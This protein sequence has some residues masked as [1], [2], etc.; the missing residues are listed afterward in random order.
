[1]K[2]SLY[3]SKECRAK[4]ERG[5][6]SVNR[7]GQLV[8]GSLGRATLFQALTGNAAYE[9]DTRG[10]G[11]DPLHYINILGSLVHRDID[12]IGRTLNI[13]DWHAAYPHSIDEEW[14]RH[15]YCTIDNTGSGWQVSYRLHE[16]DD[17]ITAPLDPQIFSPFVGQTVLGIPCV[18][19]RP[20]THYALLNSDNLRE[21]DIQAKRLLL[22]VMADEER[23]LLETPSFQELAYICS[24]V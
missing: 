11:Q 2:V 23:A 24:N 6:Q 10:R 8:V 12:T 4:V 7:R 9:L 18:T 14:F 15:P 20:A 1:M 5:I 16:S 22:E 13:K 17:L 21:S 19:A 3:N